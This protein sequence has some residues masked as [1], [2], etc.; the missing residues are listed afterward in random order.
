MVGPFGFLKRYLL[1]TVLIS[2][3][4]LI[5]DRKPIQTR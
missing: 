2:P 5:D 1:L 4:D 3:G